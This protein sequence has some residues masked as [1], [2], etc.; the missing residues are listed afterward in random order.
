MQVGDLFL[1]MDKHLTI[2]S[3]VLL[4]GTG[5]LSWAENLKAIVLKEA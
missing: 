1:G 2:A 3:Q 4:K 5:T